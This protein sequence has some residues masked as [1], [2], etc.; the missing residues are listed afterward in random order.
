MTT[1]LHS[2]LLTLALLAGV[3][4]SAAQGTA[5]SYNGRLNDGG[6]PANGS[7]DVTFTL[8]AT[9]GGGAP[10]SLTFANVATGVTNGLFAVTLDFGNAFDGHARY[11]EIG[12]RTNGNDAFTTLAPRQPILPTPYAITAG[13]LSGTLPVA[14]L[15]GSLP[16]SQL[17]GTLPLAQLPGAVLTNNATGVN[18]TGSFSGDGAGL[19]NL[20]SANLTG[21]L[22][23]RSAG[24]ANVAHLNDGGVAVHLTV[25]GNYA[26]LA[27]NSDGLRVYSLVNPARPVGV[28]HVGA[29]GDYV[30]AVALSGHYA[31]TANFYGGLRVYDISDPAN[32]NFL[33]Q[34][35]NGGSYG[36][37]IA[38]AGSYA[39][40]AD[41]GDGLRIYDISDPSKPGA[42][43]AHLNDGGS[44]QGVAVAGHYAY[45]ANGDDGL[46]VYDIAN[47]SN[48][49]AVGHVNDGGTSVGLALSGHYLYLANF[50]ALFVYDL[51]DP[52]HPVKIAQT[53]EGGGSGVAV[54]GNYAYFAQVEHGLR[55]Y[56]ISN[57][58]SPVS[59]TIANNGGQ[60]D[61]VAAA[62]G[63]VYLANDNDGL[64]TYT[65]SPLSVV[66]GPVFQG[67]GSG[68]T[69]LNLTA[70]NLSGPVTLAQL[71]GAVLTNNA[72]GVNLGGTFTGDGGG[73]INLNAT[74]ITAGTLA[75]ARLSANVALLN[76]G[77]T[78]TGANIFNNA[79]NSF[80]GNGGG[81]TSLNAAQLSS[82]NIPDGRLSDNVA[83]LNADQTFAGANSFTRSVG[84]GV[85]TPSAQLHISSGGGDG[86]PQLWVNQANAADLGRL[87]LTLG[88]DYS[89]RWD[90][91]FATNRFNIYSGQFNAD[92]LVLDSAG[93][94]GTFIGGGAGLTGLSAANLSGSVPSAS[95]TSVPAANL[96][97]AIA[98]GRLSAN[99]ALLNG[100][101]GFTTSV[102][103]GGGVRLNNTN[104]WLRGGAD[105]NHGLGW[106]GN[107][108]AFAGVA[109]DGPVLFGYGG[110][111][112]GSERDGVENL[113]LQWDNSGNVR[114]GGPI[115]GNGGG[116]SIRQNSSG[117]PNV[118]GGAGVNN[119]TA[120]TVGATVGG[121]GAANYNGQQYKNGV[122]ANFGTVGGGANNSAG[123]TATVGGGFGNVA[124]G[125]GSFVGGGGTD[126]AGHIG[127]NVAGGD[128]SVIGG[129]ISNTAGGE[130]A[131]V[132]GGAG[133]AASGDLAAVPGGISNT[134][135]GQYSLAAGRRAK[136]VHDGAFVWGDSQNADTASTAND[137]FIIRA[138]GGVGI[139]I[140]NP[141]SALHVNGTIT[142]SDFSGD[143]SG[144]TNLR[145]ATNFSGDV[146][147]NDHNLF[148][149]GDRAQGLSW[150]DSFFHSYSFGIETIHV[151]GPDLSGYA[152]GVLSTSDKHVLWWND[153]GVTVDGNV[154]AKLFGL[155]S[156]RNLKE[157]FKPVSAR[158]I[159]DKVAA[160]PITR[161]S[162]KTEKSSI[163][164]GPTAQDFKAAFDL[165]DDDR[166]ISVVDEGGV[167]LA[168]I[169]GLNQKIEEQRVENATLMRRLEKLERLLNANN[170]AAK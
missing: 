69:N 49:V 167:A 140:N 51:S 143:G 107:G 157:N 74:Q 33:A 89:K 43:I 52:A 19:G 96:T 164:L 158:E 127:G 85:T 141:Q 169:Q 32:P 110:G 135:G 82:G 168:A 116:I 124:A 16:A 30:E 37:G 147:L 68:L 9:A 133:N 5:F 54:A 35:Q 159:L 1:K 58:A 59:L 62:G 20:N 75:D 25:S 121:G 113:T 10:T 13:N 28:G 7:Y 91:G 86:T 131:T 145:L 24:L 151:D 57:P 101:P 44:A 87:R 112:L 18:L 103:A 70:A 2:F 114:V 55:V 132:G 65:Y 104:L 21:P 6:N 154:T 136:A 122:T 50:N 11:L 161:W 46:R 77:Q 155:S 81:L 78:F 98:D 94:H 109:P 56:N 27:N 12:V 100:S 63:Y 139:G 150:I 34:G 31:Y 166:H 42:S 22:T 40:L 92:M 97:G 72:T 84:L 115:G 102:T 149:R 90:F 163:H 118:I 108:R 4:R 137:Q 3:Y 60:A 45:L 23:V 80:A 61:D 8:F 126:G 153:D 71:P 41:A 48:P 39:Y 26:Y 17:S 105:I 38:V 88:G 119:V 156:D 67:D 165:G 36:I 138:R 148:L 73:V 15:S 47:P 53:A 144:L 76:G 123:G 111:A 120:G 106:Y 93:I 83:R 128:D 66:N 14:Q 79:G 64:R 95:L 117:A 162:F 129:G 29:G 160:L 152:G 125:I 130:G 142:A 146:Y 99:V 170:T 134:A